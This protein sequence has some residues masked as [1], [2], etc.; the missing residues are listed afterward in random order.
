[1]NTPFVSPQRRRLP[2][3]AMLL[4]CALLSIAACTDEDDP[5]AIRNPVNLPRII[6]TPG[7]VTLRPGATQQFAA[8][9][10]D[11]S[12]GNVITGQTVIWST[13]DSLV[14]RVSETGLVTVVGPGTAG[15]T[16]R[17]GP[18]VAVAGVVVLAPVTS[19]LLTAPATTLVPGN[20]TQLS[21]VA[22]DASGVPQAREIT[23]TSSAPTV[24]T[25]SATGLVTA[26]SVGTA[27]I[28]ATSEAQTATLPI[29]VVL[30]IPVA[31]ITLNA[32]SQT[33][34]Q[35]GTFQLTPTLRDAGGTALTGRTVTY[36]TSSSTIATV[37]TAGLVT[38]VGPG[39]ATITATSEGRTATATFTNV[40]ANGASLVLSGPLN[41]ARSYYVNVPAGTTRLV[42]TT[43]GGGAGEDVDIEV[44]PP[45]G[46][47]SVCAS[48][49][50]TSV[51]SC[52]INNPAVGMYRVLVTGFTAF[53]NVTL[54]A[55]LTP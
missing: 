45:T 14:A 54:R 24:A 51:E 42:V 21:A 37:S 17:Y 38:I 25:V 23:F 9:V 26:V 55:T 49:G 32:T 43:T 29:N 41:Q 34:G 7:S 52:T 31:T 30:T 39:T 12:T 11:G 3:T 48:E 13:A 28:T 6:I 46:T 20:T 44:F 16:A 4:G 40:L 1:M 18:S 22:R 5:L 8:E 50:A 33:L 36:S 2:V 35:G 15:I 19:V 27:T 53:N 47:A 10:R